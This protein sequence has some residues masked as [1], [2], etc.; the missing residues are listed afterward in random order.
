MDSDVPQAARVLCAPEKAG[1]P[2]QLVHIT[3]GAANF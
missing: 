3:P 2:R 1:K